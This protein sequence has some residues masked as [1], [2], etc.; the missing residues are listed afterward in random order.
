MTASEF[1]RTPIDAWAMFKRLALILSVLATV[2]GG[3]C[4]TAERVT[5]AV[6]SVDAYTAK[7][8]TLT[9]AAEGAPERRA[10]RDKQIADIN[11]NLAEHKAKIDAT[12]DTA[13]RIENGMTTL[14]GQFAQLLL[15]LV[16]TKTAQK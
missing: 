13:A 6:E 14:N 15:R 10:A 16:P 5:T 9:Q 11:S 3:V 8:E 2:L 7:I 4:W 12:A 1:S